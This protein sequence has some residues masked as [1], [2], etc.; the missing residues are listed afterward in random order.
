L[1]K[2]GGW[3]EIALRSDVWQHF[4]KIKDDKDIV[5]HASAN[6]AIET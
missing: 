2:D 1:T 5:R 6:I 4:V 3:K